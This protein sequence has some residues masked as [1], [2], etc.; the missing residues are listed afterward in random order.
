MRRAAEGRARNLAALGQAAAGVRFLR[1]ASPHGRLA[2]GRFRRLPRLR[3]RNLTDRLPPDTTL[4][5]T[6]LQ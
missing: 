1:T 3:C 4:P 2:N 5:P 6:M